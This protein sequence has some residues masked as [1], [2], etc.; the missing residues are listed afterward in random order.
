MKTGLKYAVVGLALISIGWFANEAFRPGKAFASRIP[1]YKVIAIKVG[2]DFEKE[3]ND[4]A[5]KGW[6]Y[7]SAPNNYFG[8]FE[9]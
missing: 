7:H 9:R 6:R 8:I 5:Q 4:Q 1:E 3:L 2:S